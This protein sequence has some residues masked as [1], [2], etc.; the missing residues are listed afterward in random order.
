MDKTASTAARDLIAQQAETAVAN[1]KWSRLRFI[2]NRFE[3][4]RCYRDCW[5]ALAQG[6]EATTH[7]QL[8][9][10]PGPDVS[11]S[12]VL[13]LPSTRDLGDELRILRF[14][15]DLKAHIAKVVVL[16]D[17]R[18]HPLLERSFPGVICCDPSESPPHAQLSH[19][20]AQERLAYW[21]GS[22]DQQL[23]GNFRPLT[24]AG[25]A[26]EK[27]RGIGISWFSKSRNKT[28][29]AIE[30]WASVLKNIRQP[31]Q[32]LQ[33]LEKPARIRALRELSDQR[34]RSSQPIDQMHDLDGFAAQVAGV[35]GVLTISNTT[36][37]MA[38]ALGVPCVVILDNGSI[39]N[40]P[41][42]GDTTPL[43]PSTR[44]IRRGSD[45]WAATLRRGWR[46]LRSLIPPQ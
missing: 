33:Y 35:R 46:T 44:L 36:A 8:P 4:A 34:I 2:G 40:W 10:W 14:I 12:G 18:L 27:P 43:Y 11:C 6:S 23:Q 39:T 13:V 30:D 1:Q 26:G 9:I 21:F 15:G 29:P 41:D 7:H 5:F 28:L 20:A 25:T 19:M 37:H 24:A 42:H 3:R 32:S 31:L 22:D 16:T 45:N 38:G 17:P